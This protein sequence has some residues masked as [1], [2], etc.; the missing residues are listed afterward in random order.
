MAKRKSKKQNT[1]RLVVSIIVIALAV[2]T[3]CTLFMPVFKA[4]TVATKADLW[5]AKGTDVFSAAFA[6]E[7]SS[8]MTAGTTA[9]YGLKAAEDTAF[10]ATVG[11]WAYM[12]TVFVSAGVLVFAVLDLLGLRFKLVNMILGIALAVL[13]LVTFIFALIIASK[14]TSVTTVLGSEVGT[15]TIA[16]VGMYLGCIGALL[17][18]GATVYQAKN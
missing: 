1:T 2:L 17:A 13:A 7:L 12:L 3:I 14:R 18:G 11:Y 10:V 4:F 6:G 8:D 9:L 16:R 15:R 5:V